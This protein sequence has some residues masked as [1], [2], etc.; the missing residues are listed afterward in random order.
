MKKQNKKTSS[1]FPM[2]KHHRTK[3]INVEKKAF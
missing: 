3:K 2:K 1:L